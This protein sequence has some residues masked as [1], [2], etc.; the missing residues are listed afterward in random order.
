M[1]DTNYVPRLRK[2]YDDA[3]RGKMLEQFGYKNPMEVPKI[4]K[5][6]RLLITKSKNVKSML[7]L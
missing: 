3:V 5:I 2:H 7:Y 6:N 4:E 1:A